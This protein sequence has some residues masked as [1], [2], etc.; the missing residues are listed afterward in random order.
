MIYGHHFQITQLTE[1]IEKNRLPHAMLFVGPESIGKR[2]VALVLAQRLLCENPPV[3]SFQGCGVCPS[4]VRVAKNQSENLKLIE[5]EGLNIKIDQ[6]RDVIQ[7]LSLA[8]FDRNRVV[9]IDQAHVMNPQASNALLK[10]LEE[11]S[12]N[13]YFILIAPEADSVLPTIRSRSH[14]IRFSA[15]TV[16]DLKSIKPGLPDWVYKCSRGQVHA[17]NTLCGDQGTNQRLES[18]NLL[19]AFWNEP[20]FID[21][22]KALGWRA[23]FKDREE[24]QSI[25]KNWI[26]I[27]RDVLVL[28]MN[29][30]E[31]LLNVDQIER[32]QKISFLENSKI[33]SFISQLLKTEKD[34][35]G[36]VDSVLLIE[37]L[38]VNY[39]RR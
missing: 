22:D 34:I 33:N 32:L 35:Q 10:I 21:D 20:L 9:I 15:L 25:I 16:T 27:M 38:W 30:M 3:H 4:C 39:A 17:M 36:Y 26:L 31:S 6:T 5:P 1:A 23:S 13:V 28:K 12:S 24:A 2:K 7:F 29:R 37:S 19:D 14:T 18:F 11:P 8:N